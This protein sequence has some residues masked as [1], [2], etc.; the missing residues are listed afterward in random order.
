MQKFLFYIQRILQIILLIILSIA[1][2]DHIGR[3]ENSIPDM[4]GFG[5]VGALVMQW[6]KITKR[7]D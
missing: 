1:T 3:Y 6:F 4:L 2:L 7:K 5:L